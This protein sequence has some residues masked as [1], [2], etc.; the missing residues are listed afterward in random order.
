MLTNIL[1]AA[2]EY[3]YRRKFVSILTILIILAGG[4]WAHYTLETEAYP[5]FTNPT[6]RVITLAPG[7]GAEE[8]E[9]TITIPLEKELNAIPGES[10]MRSISILGL[11]VISVV[12][13]DDTVQLQNR[14]QVLERIAQADLPDGTQ[15]GLDPD[16]GG[17]GEIYRY[18]LES[19]YFTPMS[20]RAIEDW[21]LERAFKQIPGV[22]DV[23]S[24]GGPTKNFQVNID[25]R[26]LVS[27]GI[28][29][30][31]VFTAIQNS[32]ATA[33]GNYIENNGRAYVVRG[34]ALLKG[35]DDI[36]DVVVGTDPNNNG[37]PVRIKDIGQVDIG[38][39]LRLGQFGKNDDDDALEGIVLMKRGENAS[40]I[41]ERL[42]EK[43]P[44]IRASVPDGIK[45]EKLYDRQELVQHTLDTVFHN[46]GEGITLVV[47][48]LVIFLFDLTAGL[49]A[50]IA[51]P[52]SLCL[53]LILL[54]SFHISANLLSLGAIDYGI[55]VDGAV[56]MV[57]YSFAKLCSLPGDATL[58]EKKEL[59]LTCAKQ[60]AAPILFSIAIIAV[61]FSGLGNLSGVAGKLFR[62]MVFTMGFHLIGALVSALLV[63][64]TLIGIILVRRKLSHKESPIIAVAQFIYKP[65]LGWSL[66]N[67]V[68]V[69]IGVVAS[70]GL[71][72]YL[73]PNVG[74][75][76]LPALDEGNIWLRVTVLPTSVSL[77]ESVRTAHRLRQ[78]CSKYPE[79]RN[80]TSQTGCP[81]DGTDP[82][83]FSNIEMFLDL[84]PASEWRPQ[85]HGNRAELVASL[86]K[87]LSVIPNVLL[88][89][90]Q[91]IQDNVDEAVAG[92]KGTLAIKIYGPDVEVLQK[93]GDQMADIVSRVPGLVDVANNQQM[94]QPQY[95]VVINRAESSRYGVNAG[96]IQS[97]VETAVGGKVATR[98]IDGERRFPV[99]VRFSQE[100]RNSEKALDN[101]LIDPPGPI[102][103]V[104]LTTMASIKYGY[105]PAFITRERNQR[106]M[107]IRINV[108]GRDLGSA[109]QEAEAQIKKQVKIPTGYR[110]IWA[111]QYQFLQDANER[112]LVIV[113]ATLL[114]VYLLLLAAFGSHGQALLVMCSVPLS[115]LG[116][117]SALLLTHT[118]FSVSAAV[119]FIAVS[120]VA[121]QNGVILISSINQLRSDEG[122]SA[123][124]AAYQ[125]ALSRMRPVLMTAT[126]AMC[127]LLPAAVSTG[128]G[129]QSQK[130]FAIAIIGGLFSATALTLIVLP[131]LYAMLSKSNR[132]PQ[133]A[134]AVER[135]AVNV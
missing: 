75:E 41:M 35:V 28:P 64:P 112:L 84:K 69:I 49:I 118:H 42:Y 21:Q 76:F 63:I 54:K 86:N 79:L 67:K 91:Y 85:F 27:F 61:D 50:S 24:F 126:V 92:A 133:N 90:S 110:Y 12:F 3:F 81:D 13:D 122:L 116:G 51:I 4:V 131:A 43:L 123:T 46:V 95:Q 66:R 80:V 14:Q 52:L 38:P 103:S 11:S 121:V 105:G 113:P 87:D 32:N 99:R 34:L 78:I 83:L 10:W 36:E 115:A 73:A 104:P 68:P 60:V 53:A 74:S 56:V 18:T 71:A 132:G 45:L 22:I 107:Y 102:S 39:G 109:V 37:I 16:S 135:T 77:E 114:L 129:A 98:L 111:G 82:N 93:L 1:N 65:V 6:V 47:T 97:L 124:E 70:L 100:F 8:V 72:A 108:R 94:G 59:V 26:K 89:F 25:A 23:S 15:P 134:K 62:P 30:T 128:I 117:I 57:E 119:G 88:Y 120:G 7:K 40:K 125:G 58:E 106:V 55:I 19:K 48:V 127:G 130:P 5:E 31:Q 96:D 29:L 20:R 101:I 2:I 44:E 9:R 33:G 17:I